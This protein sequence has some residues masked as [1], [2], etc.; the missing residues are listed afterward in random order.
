MAA[1]PPHDPLGRVEAL[2]DIINRAHIVIF[3]Q[4]RRVLGLDRD[5]DRAR[6]LLKESSRIVFHE[7]AAAARRARVAAQDHAIGELLDPRVPSDDAALN[8][9][10]RAAEVALAEMLER[11]QRIADEMSTI[12][13][14]GPSA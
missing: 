8:R 9:A 11:Q 12:I 5:Q 7:S 14:R 10:I 13:E 2:E 3:T 1:Q 6:S 4:H